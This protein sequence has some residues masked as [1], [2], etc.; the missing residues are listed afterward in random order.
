MTPG[1]FDPKRVSVFVAADK[2]KS[3]STGTTYTVKYTYDTPGGDVI[4][5]LRFA[6]PTMTALYGAS[7]FE[8]EKTVITESTKWS[9]PIGDAIE[10]VLPER[11]N[12]NK[13][14]PVVEYD[15]KNFTKIVKVTDR[16][17]V[18]REH[19][20]PTGNPRR[21]HDITFRATIQQ[22][23]ELVAS[24]E[25]AV[26]E[27]T[28]MESGIEFTEINRIVRR[29]K[30]TNLVA[31]HLKFGQVKQEIK[32]EKGEVIKTVMLTKPTI[33][34]G[35]RTTMPFLEF[36][37]KSAGS[38]DAVKSTIPSVLVQ[39]RKISVRFTTY[40]AVCKQLGIDPADNSDRNVANV[41]DFPD[42]EPFRE[43]DDHAAKRLR[44]V[45]PEIHEE[46][47]AAFQEFE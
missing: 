37:K 12:P 18:F 14:F 23:F 17:R 32:N 24:A 16:K 11:Y 29:E 13:D 38:R 6:I 4:D 28:S 21:D 9:M 1:S 26:I 27:K 44:E 25:S 46:A 35:E 20:G 10:E 41:D 19:V 36:V 39:G 43:L 40:S 2:D 8:D 31:M 5:Y 15:E 30:K 42:D 3:S 47:V 7:Q 45:P 33:F 34:V 22:Y